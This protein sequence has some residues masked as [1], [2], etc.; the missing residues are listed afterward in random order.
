MGTNCAKCYILGK[1]TKIT[2]EYLFKMPRILFAAFI[3]LTEESRFVKA[4]KNLQKKRYFGIF[5]P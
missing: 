4:C 3:V 5:T 2:I 1:S